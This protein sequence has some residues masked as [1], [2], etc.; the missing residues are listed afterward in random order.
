M[1]S[2]KKCLFL[3]YKISLSNCPSD[4]DALNGRQLGVI[5]LCSC[6]SKEE[7]WTFFFYINDM[8]WKL[9]SSLASEDDLIYATFGTL[10]FLFDYF[11]F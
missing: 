7:I 10:V 6:L 3:L 5:N 9:F 2:L 1:T 11:D 4:A 8:I